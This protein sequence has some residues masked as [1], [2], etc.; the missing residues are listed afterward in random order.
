MQPDLPAGPWRGFL[1]EADR[2]LSNRI[3][4]HCIGAFALVLAY[5]LPR[6]TA[7]I[8]VIGVVPHFAAAELT[9][10]AG[11]GSPLHSEYGAYIDVVTVV[12]P[13]EAYTDRLIP[14]FPNTWN[15]LKMFALEAHDL[16]LTKLERNLDRDRS[17]VQFLARAGHLNPEI[18]QE[19]YRCELRPYLQS[20]PEWHDQ[21]LEMWIEAYF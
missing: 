4:L 2:L 7:D 17:D 10:L 6:A 11:K 15:H 19:R 14:L 16:A 9:K 3:D 1:A 18:L 20:R 12:T 8:D 13:P 5:G 21:T